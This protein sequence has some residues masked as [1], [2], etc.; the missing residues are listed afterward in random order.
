MAPGSTPGY[1]MVIGGADRLDPEGRLA[2]IFL[3]LAD[4]RQPTLAL[5]DIVLISTATRHPEI[6]DQ[7]LRAHL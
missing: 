5:R 7:R 4:R 2:R 6:L 3:H 1:L